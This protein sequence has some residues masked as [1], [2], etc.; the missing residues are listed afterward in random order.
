MPCCD[1][2]DEFSQRIPS[3]F[4]DKRQQTSCHTSDNSILF[5][6]VVALIFYVRQ[7]KQ[8]F[9]LRKVYTALF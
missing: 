7:A 8:I 3:V 4:N 1:Y 5:G 6:S 9:E 2:P